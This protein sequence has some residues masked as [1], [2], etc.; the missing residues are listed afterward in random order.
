[1]AKCI[2]HNDKFKDLVEKSGLN[3]MQLEAEMNLWMTRNNTDIWP[4]L[5]QLGI[6]FKDITKEHKGIIR[7]RLSDII[8]NISEDKF[9]EIYENYTSLMGR[10]GRPGKELPFN[11]FKAFV[12]NANV[13]NYKDTFIFGHYDTI[14]NVFITTISSSPSSKEL[15]AEAIPNIAK[16][17]DVIGFAPKDVVGKYKRSGYVVSDAFFNYNFRGEEMNKFLYASNPNITK[18]IY[19]K[20][21]EDLSQ[22]EILDLDNRSLGYI[23]FRNLLDELVTNKDNYN[24]NIVNNNL[25]ELR[26]PAHQRERFLK[27]IKNGRYEYTEY[28]LIPAIKKLYDFKKVDIDEKDEN[29]LNQIVPDT[30]NQLNKLLVNYLS[31]FGIKTEYIEDI[32]NKLG[33]DSLGTVDILNKIAYVDKDN[34][35]DLPEIAGKFIAYM[36]QHNPLIT[37]TYE[38]LRKIGKYK[39]SN[40][41]ELLDII[42][43]LIAKELHNKTDVNLPKSLAE[44]IQSIIAYF[45]DLLTKARI[46]K[47]NKDIGVIVDSILSNN[48]SLI[49]ASKYK[50]GS[51]GKQVLQVSLKEALRSDSFAN[52]IV[53]KMADKGFILTG[54]VVLSEQGSIFRPE[55]NQVHDLDWVNPHNEEKT[56][57]ILDEIYPNRKHIRNIYNEGEE[58]YTHTF[59]ISP[60]GTKITNLKLEG[61]NSIVR[62]YN[63]VNDNNEIVGS[64]SNENGVE[65]SNGIE[66]K[67]IDLFMNERNKLTPTQTILESG[68]VLNMSN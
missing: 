27:E 68:I 48:K 37:S 50:P 18:R 47:I 31:N 32:Q 19:G 29:A 30:E 8:P 1:M 9:K 11:K 62:S 23:S 3:S 65:R 59:L 35:E 36:L 14:N 42:G 13:Y 60:E 28:S 57:E 58:S 22:K 39:N 21:I 66:G 5:S 56:N 55:E 63:I 24:Y 61:S 46:N 38:Q 10:G 41:D 26:V 52:S 12:S 4:T 34:T 16:N 40:K 25:K 17:F 43:E 54:S 2:I 6:E 45:F 20:N 67:A 7:N 53:N 64:Y 15:L 33:I 44:K 51:P 49:T